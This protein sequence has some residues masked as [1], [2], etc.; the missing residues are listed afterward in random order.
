V[1][2]AAPT[3]DELRAQ[4][5]SELNRRFP[6]VL[7]AWSITHTPSAFVRSP[8]GDIHLFKG[9]SLKK[10]GADALVT[11]VGDDHV[12]LDAAMPGH[13]PKRFEVALTLKA[14][15]P[16]KFAWQTND[17]E[18]PPDRISIRGRGRGASPGWDNGP[19]TPDQPEDPDKLR[20]PK[21]T[22][23]DFKA[24][25]KDEV[26]R[27]IK[28]TEHG[29]QV[30]PELPEDSTLYRLGARGGDMFKTINGHAIKTIAAARKFFREEHD[31][32]VREFV[33]AYER[34]GVPASRTIQL[35]AK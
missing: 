23:E 28:V 15:T 25:D 17:L 18:V 35:P 26:P 10:H 13:P 22:P 9:D 11:A 24:F 29:L 32:G 16:A 19:D 14:D 4:L 34:N 12:L 7:I 1:L 27:Y 5:Q 3:D 2:V 31:K 33:I 8:T 30:A 21:L 6:L 20:A